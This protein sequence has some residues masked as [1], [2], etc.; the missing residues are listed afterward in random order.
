MRILIN[1]ADIKGSEAMRD[2][3]STMLT[4]K[5]RHLS[6]RITRVEVHLRDDKSNRRGPDDNRCRMEA[7]LAGCRPFVV[8]SRSSDIYQSIAESAIKLNRAITARL[9]RLD[10]VPQ[11][12][13]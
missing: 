8:E 9:G 12:V 11:V 2:A 7:R 6:D 4:N 5:L 1:N 13:R 10:A 3:V